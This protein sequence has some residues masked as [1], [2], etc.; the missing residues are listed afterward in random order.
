MDS[1]EPGRP[2]DSAARPDLARGLVTRRTAIVGMGLG[3]ATL[4]VECQ[5]SSGDSATRVGRDRSDTEK[6]VNWSNWPD[7]IDVDDE[8]G[9]W[10]TLD[11]FT[12]KTGIAVHYTEDYNDNEGFYSL[13]KPQLDAHQD[14]GRDIWCATDWMVARMIRQG[15]VQKLDKANIPHAANLQPSLKNVAFDP[16][17]IYSLPWQSGFT[18]IGYNPKATGGKKVESVEQLLTDPTLKGKV[19]LLTEMQDT[20]GLVMLDMGIDPGKF[21]DAEFDQAVARIAQAKASGQIGRFTGNDYT[22]DLASGRTAACLA[23]TGDIVQLQ[24][25]N[26]QLGYALPPKGHVIW[27]DN[28]IIPNLARHKKNAERLIDYYYTAE[29]MATVEDW[30]NYISPVVGSQQVLLKSDPDIAKNVLIFPTPEVL[31]R[32]H[33]F[34]GLSAAEEQRYNAAFQQLVSD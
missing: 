6:V 7:Y 21:T 18:G 16:G 20:M 13:V 34:R 28:F 5:R 33:T 2:M 22:D 30:V 27:S 1:R 14:T 10:P 12:K 26:P 17:R 15:Y 29:V 25:D 23:Y 32:A 19:T 24:V 8:T 11:A 9:D 31:A 3:V 4:L